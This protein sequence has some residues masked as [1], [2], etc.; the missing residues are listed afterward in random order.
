MSDLESYIMHCYDILF[1]KVDDH[2][3]MANEERCAC[4]KLIQYEDQQPHKE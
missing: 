1:Q 2:D 4:D 3:L